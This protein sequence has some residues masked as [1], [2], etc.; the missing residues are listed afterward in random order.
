M[1]MLYNSRNETGPEWEPGMDP[2][3]WRRIEALYHSALE[4]PPELRDR[5]LA[6]ECRDDATL[7]REVRELLGRDQEPGT[8][9]DQ[10]AWER[11]AAI[12]HTV[13]LEPGTLLGP[14]RI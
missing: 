9:L 1:P 12:L 14:Y 5:F 11:G 4:H 2:L 6:D 7:C 8:M 13:E 10:P 3:R